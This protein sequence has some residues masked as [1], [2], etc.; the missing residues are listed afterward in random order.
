M[1]GHV[2]I[3]PSL[4]YKYQGQRKFIG[5]RSTIGAELKSSFATVKRSKT[6][7]TSQKVELQAASTKTGVR[8]PKGVQKRCLDLKDRVWLMPTCGSRIPTEST[9]FR[10]SWSWE[11]RGPTRRSPRET[12]LTRKT[13]TCT[14]RSFMLLRLDKE[15]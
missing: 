8:R 14:R 11:F 10:I 15:C 3:A 2:V 12:V 5:S 7:V 1:E 9:V 13:F 4:T 6:Q